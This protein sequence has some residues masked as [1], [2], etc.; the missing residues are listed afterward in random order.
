MIYLKQGD[1]LMAERT[2]TQTAVDKHGILLIARGLLT[3]LVM[4]GLGFLTAGS[5]AWRAGWAYIGVNM[6]AWATL[7]IWLFLANRELLYERTKR[8]RPPG[9]KR[10]DIIILLFFGFSWLLT[11]IVAGWDVRFGWSATFPFWVQ[12]AG[13]V[14][15]LVGCLLLAW[16]MVVNRHFEPTVRIQSDRDHRV[17][18]AGPYRW[19]R[20]PGYVGVILM[21]FIG[22]PLLLG[23]W[24]VFVPALVGTVLLV[25]RTGLEDRTLHNELPGYADFAEQ[26]RSRLLPGV[27]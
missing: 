18:S 16:S 27:W 24:T 1:F 22:S 4:G 2:H 21:F 7:G 8:R 10:W 9:S 17:I 25:V 20:H 14:I 23:H 15:T 3:P 19:V 11:M 5:L 13:A 6:V 12:V 26:T